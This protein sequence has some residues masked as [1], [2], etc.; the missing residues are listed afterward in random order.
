MK[1]LVTKQATV[2]IIEKEDDFEK[3]QP[4]ISLGTTFHYVFIP[5]SR[6]EEFL[7]TDLY[8]AL[9]PASYKAFNYYE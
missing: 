9:A 6:K 7:K 2:L 8:V 3:Y 4:D 5:L 1:K